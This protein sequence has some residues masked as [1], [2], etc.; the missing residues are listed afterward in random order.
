MLRLKRQPKNLS[1]ID[2]PDGSSQACHTSLSKRFETAP[3]R[4]NGKWDMQA[5]LPF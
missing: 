1:S 5:Q 3:E 2:Q 4:S